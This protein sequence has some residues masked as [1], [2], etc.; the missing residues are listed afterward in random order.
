MF[1]CVQYRKKSLLLWDGCASNKDVYSTIIVVD[2]V[3]M[4]DKRA[5]ETKR[6]NATSNTT[7][8]I[9]TEYTKYKYYR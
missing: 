4:Y 8:E 5:D 2:T 3:H 9:H 1:Q 6:A 7:K